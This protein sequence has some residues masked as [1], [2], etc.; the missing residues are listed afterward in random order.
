MIVRVTLCH[1]HAMKVK[2]RPE[3]AFT[4]GLNFLIGSNGSGK[5]MLL[6]SLYECDRCTK[7]YGD[8]R[9]VQYFN[10][11]TMNPH[12]SQGPPG[13]MRNIGSFMTSPLYRN[14][15]YDKPSV[16]TV[17][18]LLPEKENRCADAQ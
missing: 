1:A 14:K 4:P 6:R 17:G 5:S 16:F 8:S 11:E 18:Y 7:E 10:A 2:G 12:A 9:L 3:V 13:D 15:H